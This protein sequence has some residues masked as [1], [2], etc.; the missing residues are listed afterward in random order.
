MKQIEK[1]L[2][3]QMRI[4]NFEVEN[5]KTLFSFSNSDVQ[6]LLSCKPTIERNIDSVVADFYRQQTSIPEISLLIGD[7]DTLA[8]LQ[9]V[10]RRYIL[11]LFSGLYD[12]EY[13][14]NRLHI[15]LVHKRIG[16]EPKLYLSAIQTLKDLLHRTIAN[17]APADTDYK[18]IISALD[19]LF[20]FD[21]TL[22]FETYIRSLVSEVETANYKSEQYVRSMEEKVKERTRQL[23]EM[24][25]TDALTGLLNA[26]HLQDI[27][28]TALR[29]A[30][31]RTEPVSMIFMDVNDF[32]HINDT[33]GHQFGDEILSTVGKVIKNSTRAED[34]CFRYGGD[35]FCILLTNCREEQ[36]SDVFIDRLIQQIKEKLKDVTIS[37][38]VAQT[39]PSEYVDASTLIRMADEKMYAAKQAHKDANQTSSGPCS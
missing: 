26:R 21:I 14:N 2:L 1:T 18:A 37:I 13:V 35:E 5:R 6:A 27:V 20:F 36:A 39:G 11:D 8:R 17:A 19:K 24:S 33:Q 25:R 16:V 31:R 12:L 10:Q 15:G 34:S 9:S 7:A 38:G 32:K 3:E 29:S 22:V 4:T 23:E 28:T 30:Q